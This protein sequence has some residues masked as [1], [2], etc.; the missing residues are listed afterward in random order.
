MPLSF[1]NFKTAAVAGIIL[2]FTASSS[3]RIAGFHRQPQVHLITARDAG[4]SAVPEPE[5]ARL[6]LDNGDLRVGSRSL[7]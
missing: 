2:C 4:T 6:L 1:R 7:N 3:F 5:N